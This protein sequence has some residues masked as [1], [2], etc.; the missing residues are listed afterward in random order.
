MQSYVKILRVR[1]VRN[2]RY[3]KWLDPA[4]LRSF[5]LYCDFVFV[6]PLPTSQSGDLTDSLYQFVESVGVPDTLVTQ[7]K[8]ITATW[9]QSYSSIVG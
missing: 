5:L 7:M 6:V 3:V 8:P 9:V 1:Y 2:V 4:L